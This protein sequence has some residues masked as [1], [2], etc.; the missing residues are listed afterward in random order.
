MTPKTVIIAMQ[1]AKKPYTGIALLIRN[2]AGKAFSIASIVLNIVLRLL[3]FDYRHPRTGDKCMQLK[4][5]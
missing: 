5:D 2:G 3:F 4:N 1:L